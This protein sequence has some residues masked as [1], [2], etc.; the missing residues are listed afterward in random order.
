MAKSFKSKLALPGLTALIIGLQSLGFW[1]FYIR[2]GTHQTTEAWLILALI[3]LLDIPTFT[4]TFR[5]A[6][7]DP[8]FVTQK[9]D[10][11]CKKCGY[12]QAEGTHH[13]S[14]CERCVAQMDHHCFVV[15]NCVGQKSMRYFIQFCVW[16]L[17]MITILEAVVLWMIYNRNAVTADGLRNLSM[18]M[19]YV[20]PYGMLT[21]WVADAAE[22]LIYLDTILLVGPVGLG[23]FALVQILGLLDNLEQGTSEVLKKYGGR[24]GK[25]RSSQEALEVIFGKNASWSQMLLPF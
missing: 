2:Y 6:W 22:R 7:S 25:A 10:N 15:N 11:S 5:C 9:G 19:S 23:L 24:K 20:K 4:A 3:I 18:L 12:H 17:I 8:G 21:F 1:R 14:R 16:Q 13:C